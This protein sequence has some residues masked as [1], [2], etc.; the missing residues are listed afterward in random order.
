MQT[1]RRLWD[2]YRCSHGHHKMSPIAWPLGIGKHPACVSECLHCG[3][4]EDWAA[5]WDSAVCVGRWSNYDDFMEAHVK[6]LPPNKRDLRDLM[7]RAKL[8]LFSL[9][10]H[11]SH[12]RESRELMGNALSY[13]RHSIAALEPPPDDD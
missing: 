2:D 8:D 7:I 11:P 12:T 1:L 10:R 3:V 13:V 9:V 5:A 4:V 6:G